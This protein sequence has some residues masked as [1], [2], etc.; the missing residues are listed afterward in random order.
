MKR[1]QRIKDFQTRDKFFFA[2]PSIF[3][4][5]DYPSRLAIGVNLSD[6][7]AR[8]APFFN[9][10]IKDKMYQISRQ[11]AVELGNKYKMVGGSLPNLIPKEEFTVVEEG[12][13]EPLKYEIDR[14]TNTAR[15][16]NR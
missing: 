9:F 10:K 12:L 14:V 7:T 13:K 8:N 15:I 5:W 16:L 2:V 6:F 4:E 3:P 11:K 1:K